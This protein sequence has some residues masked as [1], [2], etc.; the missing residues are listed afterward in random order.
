MVAVTLIAFYLTIG[1]V[2]YH[3]AEGWRIVDS[4]YFTGVTITTVGY[5][6]L[7]PTHDITKIVTV[8]FAI[9]GIGIIFYSIGIIARKYFEREEE[10]LQK[11]WEETRKNPAIIPVK[12]T[13]STIKKRFSD[14]STKKAMLDGAKKHDVDAKNIMQR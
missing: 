13:L 4:F 11:I 10:R 14:K 5:G 7:T 8:I 6:D 2:F 3:F 12:S 1:T 9:S